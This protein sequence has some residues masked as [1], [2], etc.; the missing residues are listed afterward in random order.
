MMRLSASEGSPRNDA[1]VA[2][3]PHSPGRQPGR[4]RVERGDSFTL[5]GLLSSS[6]STVPTSTPRQ[7]K[8]AAILRAFRQP[9][10]AGLSSRHDLFMSSHEGSRGELTAHRPTVEGETA[11]C[12]HAR[13]PARKMLSCRSCSRGRSIP[14]AMLHGHPPLFIS[15]RGQPASSVTWTEQS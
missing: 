10:P 3:T 1:A 9:R 13:Q 8:P 12:N 7:S 2:E 15:H 11:P 5:S 14:H 4:M 6:P